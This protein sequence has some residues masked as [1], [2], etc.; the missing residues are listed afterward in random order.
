MQRARKLAVGI[1]KP[2][3]QR[4]GQDL[5]DLLGR[6]HWRQM[7][8]H[9]GCFAL[10]AVKRIRDHAVPTCIVDHAEAQRALE[11][12][13][14]QSHRAR[15]RLKYAERLANFAQK[16][17]ARNSELDA[18][19]RAVEKPR[20]QHLLEILY[21]ASNRWLRDIDA[22]SGQPEALIFRDRS[23]IP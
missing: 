6:V 18:L 4:S 10:K 23:E 13:C 21:L 15:G 16:Q 8:A 17:F 9:L 5:G 7:N 11:P 1:D 12:G 14:N 19:R 2:A 3:V 22:L 20:A